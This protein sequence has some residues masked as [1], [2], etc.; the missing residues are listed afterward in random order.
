MSTLARE[1]Y[2]SVDIESDGPIPGPFSMVSIGASAACYKMSNG[3]VAPLM[4]DE[5]ANQFYAEIKPIS[6]N[7][8]P[9]A[10]A[11]SGFSR[12]YIMENGREAVEVMNEFVAWVESIRARP[13]VTGVVFA[14]YPLGFDWM[15]T[16][17]YL[18]NFAEKGSPFGH[19]KHIDMKTL[20]AAKSDKLIGHSV[21][22]RMPKSLMSKRSSRARCSPTC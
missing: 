7:W 1:V 15:F 21:K 4:I 14:A 9:D 12:E 6:E 16:Y 5:P 19:S 10:L 20:Y 2:I 17:W 11:V 22:N 13:S 18:V 8:Q 3:F